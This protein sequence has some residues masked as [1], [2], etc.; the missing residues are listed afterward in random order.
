MDKLVQFEE[1]FNSRSE[2]WWG[3][4]VIGYLRPDQF[5]DHLTVITN[6]DQEG[7]AEDDPTPRGCSKT[8]GPN[9]W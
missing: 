1:D 5:L 2:M 8:T 9:I 6:N 7:F 4:G 3:G